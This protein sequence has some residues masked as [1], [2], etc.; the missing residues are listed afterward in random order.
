[1]NPIRDLLT[2]LGIAVVGI[3]LGIA[4]RIA[5]PI[6][7]IELKAVDFLGTDYLLVAAVG[8][9]A[10]IATVLV[11]TA[12]ALSSGH[13]L[14]T[15]DPES[16]PAVPELGGELDRFIDGSA[17]RRHFRSAE[18]DDI[19]HRLRAAATTAVMHREGC[20]HTAASEQIE[21][22]DWTDDIEA[23]AF[24]GGPGAPRPPLVARAEAAIDGQLWVQ[25]GARRAVAAVIDLAEDG[26]R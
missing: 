10:G 15:P 24:L 23:A 3:G 1:M 6:D 2:L 9:V 21:N 25:R 17:G 22:G 16:V 13:Q 14:S 19:R 7:T 12:R 20:D 5:P 8:A 18:R 11:V 26:E 4:V